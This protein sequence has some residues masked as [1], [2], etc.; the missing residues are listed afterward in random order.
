MTTLVTAN[1]QHGLPGK[2]ASNALDVVMSFEP[3]LV[4]LNEV[5][6]NRNNL[7][8]ELGP[9]LLPGRIEV[10]D[11]PSLAGMVWMRLFP[12]GQVIG[13]DTSE[14]EIVGGRP[15]L[16]SKGGDVEDV[17]G[18]KSRL[19]DNDASVVHVRNRRTRQREVLILFHLTSHVQEGPNR[20]RAGARSEMHRQQRRSL[21]RFIERQQER[22]RKVWA[23][24]DTNWDEMPLEGLRSCWDGRRALGTHGPRAIDII[25]GEDRFKD[26]ATRDIG[27][28]HKLVVATA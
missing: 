28:D 18:R 11:F 2:V 17:P 5:E 24:G 22:G 21:E 8:K 15:L 9:L 4:G 20:Y 7:L 10:G 14:Y 16:L 19:D 3:H 23:M 27:S 6:G 13:V 1:I 25:Y 26:A 12:G